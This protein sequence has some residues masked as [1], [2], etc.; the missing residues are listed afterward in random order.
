MWIT[1]YHDRETSRHPPRENHFKAID[2]ATD[3]KHSRM[4]LIMLT[5]TASLARALGS[6]QQAEA[7]SD[8]DPAPAM[9]EYAS[10]TVSHN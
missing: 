9:V 6:W 7:S 4:V 8:F 2:V 5:V 10:R 3:P 1:N